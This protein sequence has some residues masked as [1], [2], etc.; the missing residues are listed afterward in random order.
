[1]RQAGSSL[2]HGMGHKSVSDRHKAVA[3]DNAEDNPFAEF[4]KAG[5]A[6]ATKW[7]IWEILKDRQEGLT[8][9]EILQQISERELRTFGKNPSGQVR[10]R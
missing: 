9:K 7:C 6:R 3:R 4:P 10:Q 1:M 8:T 5:T 2:G